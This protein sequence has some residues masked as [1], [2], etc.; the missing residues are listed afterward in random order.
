MDFSNIA[1]Q[2]NETSDPSVAAAKANEEKAT[3]GG[4][5]QQTKTKEAHTRQK[6]QMSQTTA[7]PKK[8]DVSYASEEARTEREEIKMIESA[9]S[10]WRQE[11]MEAAGEEGPD[12]PFVDV[13][14]FMNQKQ[15]EVKKQMKAAAKA[16]KTGVTEATDYEMDYEL[17]QT[18]DKRIA[19]QEKKVPKSRI[20]GESEK[21]RDEVFY[22]A[23]DQSGPKEILAKQ[24]ASHSK[25]P[26]EHPSLG[27]G[28]NF[29][30]MSGAKMKGPKRK[31][32][33]KKRDGKEFKSKGSKRSADRIAKNISGNRKS[34]PMA[35][36][37]YKSRP[38]ES[39]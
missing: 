13:M 32:V 24:K 29:D 4:Q 39:D 21:N 38:G 1:R 3:L 15:E 23:L 19:D 2:L 18:R 14:P 37:P 30:K 10:D 17:S 20:K 7:P 6:A 9:K 27:D 11:L 28:H 36:D 33:I 26:L 31:G 34:G 16:E 22:R 5:T 12:H 35:Q 8:S 25:K